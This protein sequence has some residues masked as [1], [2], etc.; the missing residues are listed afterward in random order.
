MRID[1]KPIEAPLRGKGGED[2]L[3]RG[4]PFAQPAGDEVSPDISEQQAR[5]ELVRPV[6]GTDPALTPFAKTE[7]D[8]QQFP[9]RLRQAAGT[10]FAIDDPG[11]L[12]FLE[13]LGEERR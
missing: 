6:V 12:E 11:S 5:V 3:D 2:E 10:G 9:T 8:R 4:A 13:S 1:D 7:D